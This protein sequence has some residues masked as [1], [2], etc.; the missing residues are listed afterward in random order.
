MQK[1]QISQE[2][3][4]D[5]TTFLKMHERPMPL[6]LGK[7]K[8]HF[9][10][11]N[12]GIRLSICDYQ[13]HAPTQ[14]IYNAFPRVFGFGFCLSGDITNRPSEFRDSGIIRSGQSA[15]FHFDGGDMLE[16]VSTERVIRIDLILD[17]DNFLNTLHKD[18][19]FTFPVI[20]KIL[21]RPGRLFHPLTCAMQR[22]LLQMINC[23]YRGATRDFFMESKAL[24]LVTYKLDQLGE[25]QNRLSPQAC[26][27]DELIDRARYAG[28]LLTQDL[29]NPPAISAICSQAGMC[30]T[31]L[32]QCFQ[33]VYGTTPFEY[34]RM[35]RL[36]TAQR[37]LHQGG[38]NVT[39]VAFAVG[40]TSL[41]HFSKAF[42]HYTGCLP[43]HYRPK[44]FGKKQDTAKNCRRKT[45][46]R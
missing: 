3:H 34:L 10:A 26:L 27:D 38:M 36:E 24:E 1:I 7:G 25:K 12:S 37:L 19:D 8:V 2:R 17:P 23:P 31:K 40:Y 35:K 16:T 32:H 41:S 33:N 21:K 39:Q 44:N 11:L 5:D 22:A 14:L 30:R 9:M 28:R 20:E 43:S 29:E 6:D 42:K 45:K 46:H 4:V 15:V 18:T 13:M